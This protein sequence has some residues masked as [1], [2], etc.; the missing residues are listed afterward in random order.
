MDSNAPYIASLTRE[1]FM[2]YEMKMTYSSLKVHIQ[3]E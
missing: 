3:K 1:P 2:Y